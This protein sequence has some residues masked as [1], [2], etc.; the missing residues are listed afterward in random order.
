MRAWIAEK[1]GTPDEALV[2]RDDWP[3][4]EP[5]PDDV[6]IKV[7]AT[8]LNF[9]EIDT[10]AGEYKAVSPPPPFI[11]GMEALGVVDQAGE[12]VKDWIGKRVVAIPNGAIGGYAEY[13]V[14]SVDSTFEM[15]H[16]MAQAD[17]AAIFF[18]FHLGWLALYDRA[19]VT[20]D[21]TV[22]VHAGAGG[23]GSAVI[24]LAK[25]KGARVIATAGSDDK[26]ALCREL[27]ADVAINYRE[28]DWVEAVN[29]ATGWRGVDVAFD[30]I[31]GEV[32]Q[33]TF[34]TMG[35]NGRHLIVGLRLGHR[36]RR[37]RHQPEA[38]R[39]RQLLPRRRVRRVHA[40]LHELPQAVGRA[41][42]LVDTG[43]PRTARRSCSRCS[44][45]AP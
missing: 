6:R 23:A 38:V 3:E 32:T 14:A 10:I 41:Q 45:T 5:G 16:D 21:D 12:H 24:Q 13:A 37:H 30:A 7:Q 22:L 4:P 27:G 9:N 44:P 1:Y 15:P 25:A 40:R 18:P 35:F 33:Q 20:S 17:A 43:G 8:T 11:P 42:L 28:T 19:K 34:K 36:R 39:L 2:L 31:G 29:E 26:L